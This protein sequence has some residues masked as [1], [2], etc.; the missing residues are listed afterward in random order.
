MLTIRAGRIVIRPDG[1]V[2]VHLPDGEIIHGLPK[3]KVEET[4]DWLDERAAES[5][6]QEKHDANTFA[7]P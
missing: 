1:L 5:K 6:K 4:L 7:S 3:S 2:D